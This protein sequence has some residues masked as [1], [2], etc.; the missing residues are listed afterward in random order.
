MAGREKYLLAALPL[1][2]LAVGFWL[3]VLGPKK[4]EAGDLGEK[5]TA[6][7]QQIQESESRIAIAEQ[8]RESFPD[9]YAEI[10]KLGAAVP[11]DDDQATLIHE[12][13]KIG[14]D[15]D[16]KFLSFTLT[17][18]SG[19]APP[20][21]PAPA[22]GEPTATDATGTPVATGMATEAAAA[23]LPLGA[24]VG[25][26]GLPMMPYDLNYTGEFFD[27][28]DVFADL[29]S[30]VKV[31]AAGGKPRIEGRLLTVNGFSLEADPETGF[32]RVSAKLA[33]NSY[34]VPAEQGL[35]AGATPAGPAPVGSDAAP[36]PTS[37]GAGTP[38]PATAAVT[39]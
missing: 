6:L 25:S 30:Q 29:D 17:E 31:S 39:P 35:A 28:A 32:P 23:L 19:E 27:M 37:G 12:L 2:A 5:A 22:A 11:E 10:V 34:L 13:T 1:I 38:A 7:E 21:P 33:V 15:N 9:N 8:A 4:Q 20:A 3:L 24:T 14:R 26:A 36:V 16:V 18:G